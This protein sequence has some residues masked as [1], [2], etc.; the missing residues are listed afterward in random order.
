MQ[1][2]IERWGRVPYGRAL[3]LQK[4]AVEDRRAGRTPDRL[5][6]LEHPPVVTCGR[7]THPENL[8][9]PESELLA[10]GIDLHHVARGGDVTYHAPGQLVG[11]PIVDL[12][13]RGEPDVVAWLRRLEHGLILSLAELG[14]SAERATGKTGVFAAG[15]APL[16]KLASI[17]VGLRGWVTWHGF[18]LN[19]TLDLSGFDVI[20]PCGLADVE[21]SSVAHELGVDA[22]AALFERSVDVV[23]GV[24]GRE[25]DR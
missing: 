7:S 23:A 21:M 5:L 3:E 12:E 2:E 4:Q 22:G 15:S 24:F 6:L 14:V 18:A 20:V 11:Y 17:G 16:R 13:A 1:L 8:R 10:R 19:V 9:V 25:L